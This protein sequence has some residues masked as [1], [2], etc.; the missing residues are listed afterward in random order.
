MD[1]ALAIYKPG[2]GY[3]TRVL[4]AIGAGTLVLAGALWTAGQL[5][6]MPQ[7]TQLYWQAGAAVA[8][9]AVF[10]SLI[11]YLLNKPNIVDFMIATEAEMKK[12]N[13]P[14]RKEI[15]GSTV[16]VIAGT[17]LLAALLFLINI[18]FAWIF[19]QIGVLE[20]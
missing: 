19:Q 11:Y 14:S 6:V 5:S 8:I 12:V 13:W 15:I 1:M 3:W 2:Q 7:D 4:T 9:I 16:V 10:G 20:G 18:G 17:L